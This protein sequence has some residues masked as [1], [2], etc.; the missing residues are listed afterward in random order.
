MTRTNYVV[1][2]VCGM[3]LMACKPWTLLSEEDTVLIAGEGDTM[4]TVDTADEHEIATVTISYLEELTRDASDLVTTRYIYKDAD[5]YTNTKHWGN[6]DLPLTTTEYV[7]TYEG[8]ISLGIDMSEIRYSVDDAQNQIV[9]ELPEI[10]IVANE[11][12]ADSFAYVSSKNSIFNETQMEDITDLI[13][14]LKEA[15][16]DKVMADAD[17]L[18][19]VQVRAESV[20][21]RLITMSDLAADY[22]VTFR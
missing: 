4:L 11:I 21:T 15:E 17:L 5:V 22:E 8:T 1:G 9:V 14:G 10:K 18:A 13:A 2:L 19:D 3:L 16:A 6:M 7:Y 20:I 12:D